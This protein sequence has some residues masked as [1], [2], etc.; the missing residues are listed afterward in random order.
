MTSRRIKWAINA[1]DG[2]PRI[3]GGA[4]G[5]VDDAT[6]AITLSERSREMIDEVLEQNPQPTESFV[7]SGYD[8]G[9]EVHRLVQAKHRA[10]IPVR[11]RLPSGMLGAQDLEPGS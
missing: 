7:V 1:S 10:G 5:D 11:D 4:I 8:L 3:V 6:G 9:H 2:S